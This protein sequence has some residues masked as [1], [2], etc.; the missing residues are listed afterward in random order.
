MPTATQSMTLSA[1]LKVVL[2]VSVT[3]LVGTSLR[4]PVWKYFLGQQAALPHDHQ[5]LHSS[6]LEPPPPLLPNASHPAQVFVSRNWLPAVS[7]CKGGPNSK[8]SQLGPP[9]EPDEIID[10]LWQS[11][12]EKALCD[13]EK[14][15]PAAVQ[16]WLSPA[17]S[18]ASLAAR[19]QL[20]PSCNVSRE[21]C[22]AVTTLRGERW[23]KHVTF[24]LGMLT[25][26]L[27]EHSDHIFVNL[28]PPRKTQT[29]GQWTMSMCGPSRSL[30]A[31]IFWN[32]DQL[33]P[34][35]DPHG[36]TALIVLGDDLHKFEKRV[37]L[38]VTGF[39]RKYRPD[40]FSAYAY[41]FPD[42]YPDFPKHL[43]TWAP[44]S[45][46][47]DFTAVKTIN[48][49]ADRDVLVSGAISLPWYPCRKLAWD[50]CKQFPTLVSCLAHPGY[51]PKQPKNTGKEYA[52]E[53]RRHTFG[54]ATCEGSLYAVAKLFEIGAA[55]A[56][57]VTTE[58]MGTVL[59]ALGLAPHVHFFIADCQNSS[60]LQS[61][62]GSLINVA[63]ERVNRIR[64]RGQRVLQ[65]LHT[66]KQRSRALM[67]RAV[68]NALLRRMSTETH[69]ARLPDG[70]YV[71]QGI[72]LAEMGKCWRFEG[73]HLHTRP[74]L[75]HY[76]D[77]DMQMQRHGKP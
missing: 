24:E 4:F 15:L 40:I 22:V 27:L 13:T 30:D 12:T 29:L 64:E 9:I 16:A 20:C 74:P 2:L 76:F 21:L 11:S 18:A 69:P 56:G 48:T 14:T 34:A 57:V 7:E 10:S 8:C 63:A 75:A 55:G 59:Q 61:S 70:P 52:R 23:S 73:L 51:K 66:S 62:F 46:T 72:H 28:E 17:T 35:V 36:E 68:A 37:R 45:A 26:G 38:Q 31:V 49:T 42:A 54:L 58:R 71:G 53:I 33:H 1:L 5:E 44:H 50:M 65:R 77:K 60:T 67:L 43:I 41:E 25:R 6:T 3:V 19:S 47:P 32:A 39:M